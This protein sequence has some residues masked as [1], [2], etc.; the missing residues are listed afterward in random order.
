MGFEAQGFSA[1][2]LRFALRSDD[3]NAQWAAVKAGLGVGF[4]SNYLLRSEPLVQ[5]VL[6]ELKL[7]EFPVW[8]TVHRELQTSARIRTIYNFL[9]TQVAKTLQTET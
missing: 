6:G 9:A 3:L 5:A 8:L 1:K 7:P 4:M 2:D